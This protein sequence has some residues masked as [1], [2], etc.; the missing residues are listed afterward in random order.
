MRIGF[1]GGVGEVTGSRHLLEAEGLKVLLDCGLFQGHRAEAIAKNKRNPFDPKTLDAVLLSHAHVDHC[2]SLP[3]LVKNGYA[4]PIHCTDA[5][6][7]IVQIM[8]LDS[9]HLQER[10]AEFF[11]K[12]HARAGDAERIE[13]LYTEDDAKACLGRLLVH[14]YG[15]WVPLDDKVRFRFHNAGHVLGSA[16]I[17]V[18]V[19]TVK[20]VRRVFFTGDL[21][22]RKSLLMAPPAVPKNVDYLLIESTYGDRNHDPIDRVE[23]ILKTVVERAVDEKGK[24]L[25]PSFAL[26]RT[27]E[28]IFILDKMIRQGQI[29]AIPVY[30][31]SPMAVNITEIFSRH[32]D[33]FSFSPE[34]KKYV[35]ESGD[36]FDFKA[37]RYVRSVDESQ[38]LN[39]KK[40]PMIILSASGM[41]EGGR[42]LHHLRNNLD[43]DTTTI[44]IVGYQAQGTLGRRLQEGAKKVKV[45]GL[46]HSVWARVETLHTFS[47]HADQSDL[48]WFMKSLDPRPRTIFLVHGDACD[49]AALKERL[50][51]EGI[52]RVESPEYGETFDLE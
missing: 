4:G 6:R 36:P 18:E 45:F 9:A 40:G 50:K 1:Y 32:L 19:K 46:E 41:C 14:P 39:S 42:I 52:T 12:I 5:T 21:G 33:G 49:R 31:D 26:E 47:A 13:P 25:I 51:V 16:M 2:G 28:I 29:P 8:L 43:K 3:L 30:V 20:G 23:S 35:A 15:I 37:L 10:D 24:I 7:D 38:A 34:F 17:E 11:N 48:M 22:R 27:Q 44:L